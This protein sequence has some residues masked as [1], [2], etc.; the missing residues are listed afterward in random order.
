[1]TDTTDTIVID[2]VNDFSFFG[3][4]FDYN[5]VSYF[6]ASAG[7]SAGTSTVNATISGDH[8]MFGLEFHAEGDRQLATN[9]TDIDDG[10]IRYIGQ[11]RLWQGD[12]TINLTNT[13][14]ETLMG[15]RDSDHDITIDMYSHL[16]RLRTGESNTTMINTGA[17]GAG[18]I[19][20]ESGD[21][22]INVGDGNVD[23]ILAGRYG[24]TG[25]NVISNGN[26][27]VSFLELS[28][29]TQ[30][31]TVGAADIR[32]IKINDDGTSANITANSTGEIDVLRSFVETTVNASARLGLIELGNG[33]DTLTFGNGAKT[34]STGSG[35]DTATFT[36]GYTDFISLSSGADTL[37][38]SGTAGIGSVDL[39]SGNNTLNATG[40]SILTLTANSDDDTFNIDNARV[41]TIRASNGTNTL[42]LT[43]DSTVESYFGY[44]GSDIITVANTA[45][46]TQLAVGEGI[47][48]ISVTDS[49]RIE[50][51]TAYSGDDTLTVSDSASLSTVDL[52]N[53]SNSVIVNGDGDIQYLKTNSDFDTVTVSDT[54]RIRAID[55]G[56]GGSSVT[57]STND[58]IS[59]VTASE[60]TDT[61]FVSG[62]VGQID[63]WRGDDVVTT[64][65]GFVGQIA[66]SGG[67]NYSG[68]DADTVTVGNGGAGRIWAGDGN[69]TVF[70]NNGF[71]SNV[72]LGNGDDVVHVAASSGGAGAAISGGGGL[73]MVDFSG[74]AQAINF[75]MNFS[76]RWQNVSNL[77][78]A[79]DFAVADLGFFS[80]TSSVENLTGTAFND[81]LKGRG[82]S[83]V[84]DGA[85]L[86]RGGL[87]DDEIFGLTGDDVLEGG[88]GADRVLG[89]GGDDTLIGEGGADL[90][91][92]GGDAD[93]LDGGAGGDTMYGGAGTDVLLGD[94]GSD[95]LYGGTDADQ[96]NGGSG[97]DLLY[98]EGGSD[99][100]IFDDVANL[101]VDRIKDWEDG[102]DV[103]DL[104]DF[105]FANFGDVSALS[106]SFGATDVRIAFAAGK[107]IVIENFDIADF[108][109]SDVI[110]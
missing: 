109:A 31:I 1:M 3:S 80:V 45:R 93:I 95:R 63:T 32:E 68:A 43:G 55:L 39:G 2:G 110:L 72:I 78:D 86:I 76:G 53:G 9:F 62:G 27:R 64:G 69:D 81:I 54:G 70:L 66:V 104:S 12:H 10:N 6:T 26:G 24:E 23:Y 75:T 50:A 13:G 7:T 79:F 94:A 48:T 102:L 87:G 108:D 73:D 18:T 105:G 41:E 99:A 106:S 37:N 101:G 11:L 58:F 15:F 14:I 30:T 88:G 84:S 36:G 100:F 65:D 90:M 97:A 35:D 5:G 25:D 71:V 103:I 33:N 77:T 98:G 46:I 56:D 67:S 85:N 4:N 51:L 44:G 28:G 42:N 74:A 22:T 34:V 20:M 47:N 40:G 59:S 82:E 16:I 19:R 91:F 57:L 83:S 17:E 61:I 96:L 21:N 38:L 107:A 52:G 92:G 60:G 8:F 29:S 49:A 89:G